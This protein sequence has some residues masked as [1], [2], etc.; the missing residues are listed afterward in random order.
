MYGV[1]YQCD[2]NKCNG[3]N[4][5]A[6]EENAI[7]PYTVDPIIEPTDEPTTEMITDPITETI[8]TEATTDAAQERLIL[9]T[10]L[11]CVLLQ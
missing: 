10:L 2:T 7:P 4:R 5:M 6:L 3:L 11:A 8:S 9:G 1:Q